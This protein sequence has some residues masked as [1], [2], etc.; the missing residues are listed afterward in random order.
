V[1]RRE[2]ITLLGGAAAWPLAARAQQATP[3]VG[4][5]SAGSPAPDV[6]ILPSFR[7]ALAEAGY[8]EG[9][10]VRIEY[11]YAEGRYDRLSELATDLVRRDVSVIVALPNVNAARAAKAATSAIP[12]VFMASDDPVKQGLVASL[13]RPGG[14]V[15]GVNYLISELGAKR[16]GL[17][18]ELLPAAVRFAALVNPNATI[19]EGFT[20]DLTA[21]ASTLG[22]RVEIVHARDDRELEDAFATLARDKIDALMVAPDT[23]FASRRVQI[24]TLATRHAIPAIYAVRLYVENGGLVSY[25]PSIRDTYRRLGVY[26]GRI[27]KGDKPVD[28]PVVQS[29][30]LDLVINMPTARALGVTVPPTLLAIADEVIE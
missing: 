30:K 26:A 4:F 5:L 9:Q 27:L 14:N 28:L 3:V 8:V 19:A 6:T 1:K 23:F 18:R 16:L 7:Q 20:K 15:T 21:A 24:V 17:L 11:R 22:I 2:F 13:N 12:I 10:N 25:G 29:T